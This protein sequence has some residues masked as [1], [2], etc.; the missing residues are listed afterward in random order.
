MSYRDEKV[1]TSC[2]IAT[3]T[4]NFD[5]MSASFNTRTTVSYHF[6]TMLVMRRKLA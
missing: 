4:F 1:T 3:N 5:N 6:N 2:Q